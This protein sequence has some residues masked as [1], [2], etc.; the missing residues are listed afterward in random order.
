MVSLF[1]SWIR[2]LSSPA[3]ILWCH[4]PPIVPRTTTVPR[5]REGVP[6]FYSEKIPAFNLYVFSLLAS[7]SV[8]QSFAGSSL[9][10]CMWQNFFF[11]VLSLVSSSHGFVLSF[12]GQPSSGATRHLSSRVRRYNLD[13]GNLKRRRCLWFQ[14]G[15]YYLYFILMYISW[16]LCHSVSYRKQLMTML[17]LWQIFFDNVIFI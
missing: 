4:S 9:W 1:F 6:D 13:S 2:S 12:L 3:A 7:C 5:I 15:N 17:C 16:C 11:T 10:P 8:I 14:F